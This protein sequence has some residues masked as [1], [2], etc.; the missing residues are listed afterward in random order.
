MINSVLTYEHTWLDAHH[1]K[2]MAGTEWWRLDG[3]DLSATAYGF[4]VP[5]ASS[6]ALGS[7]GP[8]KDASDGIPQ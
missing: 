5:V 1:F 3:Y 8:T 4:S 2:V 7:A 6:I